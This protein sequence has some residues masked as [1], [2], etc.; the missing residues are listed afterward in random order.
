MNIGKF[1]L[2]NHFPFWSI[3]CQDYWDVVAGLVGSCLCHLNWHLYQHFNHL[4]YSNIKLVW[5]F[6]SH[7]ILYWFNYLWNQCALLA[8]I[9]LRI[10]FFWGGSVYELGIWLCIRYVR[11]TYFFCLKSFLF[12]HISLNLFCQ[13]LF[14][15]LFLCTTHKINRQTIAHLKDYFWN[16]LM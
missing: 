2:R 15:F 5:F 10:F 9:C 16:H 11:V 6:F 3:L 14:A 8:S 13:Q 1:S 7:G 12:L 4:L